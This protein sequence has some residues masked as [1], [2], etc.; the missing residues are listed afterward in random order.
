MPLPDAL[1]VLV[2][3]LGAAILA[4]WVTSACDLAGGSTQTATTSAAPSPT[5]TARALAPPPA[6]GDVKALLEEIAP[7]VQRL[8]GL[9]GWSVPVE[10]V[11]RDRLKTLLTEAIQ[12]DYP[13]EEAEID[14]LQLE[15]LGLLPAGS[16]LRALRMDLLEEQVIGFYDS[17][18]QEMFAVGD[19][20]T[21]D[22]MLRFVLAHEYIH[23][24]Q[25]R[26]FDLDKLEEAL[27]GN[28]DATAALGA[29]VEGDATLA[30]L[31]YSALNIDQQALADAAPG[32][33]DGGLDRTPRILREALMFPYD[34]GTRFVGA[35]V[36]E[37]GWDAVDDA[38]SRLPA[39]TEQIIHPEKYQTGEAPMEV[40]L[41][42]LSRALPDGWREARRSVAGEFFIRVMLEGC[43]GLTSA[44]ESAAG[45][46]GDAYAVYLDPARRGL[47]VW[48][49]RWDSEADLTQFWDA[50]AAYFA[51]CG[52]GAGDAVAA[53]R[54]LEWSGA[55]RW[56]RALRL[57]DSVVFVAGQSAESV[58]AAVAALSRP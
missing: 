8:R 29:L 53:E 17:K 51:P 57:A 55:G 58:Q 7:E 1:R 25:D 49:T 32:E 14:R 47:F 45:W 48:V 43:D 34:Y 27:S 2:R 52:L 9:A 41:P 50:L 56:V 54:S 3:T 40:T 30:G 23:A 10:L 36:S 42:E 33:G 15:L 35:L 28:D 11:G 19:A 5:I 21:P 38:F 22:A 39:S 44:A 24:L 18:K 4:A 31:Q 16:D 20:A 46:G 13:Q 26:A 12:Q 37:E 6:A